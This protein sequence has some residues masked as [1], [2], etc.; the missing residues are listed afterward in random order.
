[1]SF[2]PPSGWSQRTGAR[3]FPDVISERRRGDTHVIVGEVPVKSKE[4][5][6]LA[7]MVVRRWN[8]HLEQM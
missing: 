8:R 2:S 6:I 5:K 1:M 4:K 7:T 3:F